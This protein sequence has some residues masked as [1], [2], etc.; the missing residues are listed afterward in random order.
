MLILVDFEKYAVSVQ[1][2][3]L[4]NSVAHLYIPEIMQIMRTCHTAFYNY[5]NEVI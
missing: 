1:D 5:G 3:I 2:L 4:N